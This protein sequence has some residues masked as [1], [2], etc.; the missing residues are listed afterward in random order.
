MESTSY[1]HAGK[2]INGRYRLISSIENGD[3]AQVYL[4][5]D[6]R[7]RKQTVVK[8]FD[9][10]SFETDE[11]LE[12]FQNEMKNLSRSNHP[13]LVKILDWGFGENQYVV[14]EFIAGGNLRAMLQR[15][16]MLSIAQITFIVIEIL[17]GVSYLH[18]KGMV[19]GDLKPENIIFDI[20]GELKITDS[21]FGRLYSRNYESTLA[22][23]HPY[24]SPE[25][26]SGEFTSPST[27][28][29][30]IAKIFT[31]LIETKLLQE[32]VLLEVSKPESPH[33]NSNILQDLIS[34]FAGALSKK[35]T[36]RPSALELLNRV[37]QIN[38]YNEK[39]S[40]LP[41]ENG[42]NPRI[43]GGIAQ[44]P[45]VVY[46]ETSPKLKAQFRSA[47]LYLKT[48]LRRWSW[49]LVMA[50]I[51]LGIALLINQNTEEE[52]TK[53]AVVPE[54]SGLSASDLFEQVDDFWIL[55]EAL[56]RK[57]GSQAGEILETIPPVGSE[58]AKGEELTYFLSLGPELRVIPMGLTGLTLEEA[59]SA[60]LG[61]RLRLGKTS[62]VFHEEIA[63][64]LVIGPS[65]LITELPTGSEVDLNISSGPELRVVPNS[66]VGGIFE[67]AET[68]IV[69]EG[70]Q[71]R[72][73]EL[74]HPNIS[75]GIVIR[76]NPESGTPIMR[77]G[78]V[79][80]FVSKGPETTE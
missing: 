22:S 14:T 4:A 43:L 1:L 77:D 16:E 50:S 15:N 64:G 76:L 69:L 55:K 8:V 29:Y 35:P 21:G 47:I 17:K 23:E 79:E 33:N 40:L 13:N 74:F 78:I 60:L 46:A 70:L 7:V 73:L 42:L 52:V 5:D 39:P 11:F 27:D 24:I 56:T 2:V 18:E 3:L 36:E 63:T 54:I 49:L 80:I 38:Q 10:T 68:A 28:V 12:D 44:Q 9:G 53:T 19:H 25:Q 71:V 65:I 58:L 45:K 20:N 6:I 67:S 66:L 34:T 37:I 62:Q 31:E 61:S 48:H 57:D 51:V 75:S 26:R 41:I 72:K 30:A 59:E 32:Q